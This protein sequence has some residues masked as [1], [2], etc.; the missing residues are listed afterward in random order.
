MFSL[1][2]AFHFLAALLYL[3]IMFF[4]PELVS[5]FLCD[6]N[7]VNCGAQRVCI[8]STEIKKYVGLRGQKHYL[9]SFLFLLYC[10]VRYYVFLKL[11][12]ALG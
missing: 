2:L 9:G 10:S 8:L 3:I 6:F 12:S 7:S 4:G 5:L 1:L 11:K